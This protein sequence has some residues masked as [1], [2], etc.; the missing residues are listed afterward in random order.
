MRQYA[1]ILIVLLLMSGC[2][3]VKK[4]VFAPEEPLRVVSVMRDRTDPDMAEE[5]PK[6]IIGTFRIS[7]DVLFESL[8]Y[9][10]VIISSEDRPVTQITIEG[11]SPLFSKRMTRI[12]E[13]KRF[14]AD[15]TKA[16]RLLESEEE[17]PKAHSLVVRSI[18]K[19]VTALSGMKGERIIICMSDL[20]ESSSDF[21]YYRKDDF[22]EAEW[23]PLAVAAKYDRMAPL[24]KNVDV[25]IYFLYQAKDYQDQQGYDTALKVTKLWLESHGVKVVSAPNLLA[26]G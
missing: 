6:K 17:K 11:A 19:E 12:S 3:K 21:S 10:G 13:L 9:R 14:R 23:N 16:I 18:A 7:D 15:V 1:L 2:D 20:A 25:T 22:K 8:V 24:P 4:A 26:N 5:D